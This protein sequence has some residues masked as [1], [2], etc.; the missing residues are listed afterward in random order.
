MEWFAFH[1]AS[2]TEL[3]TLAQD[4]KWSSNPFVVSQAWS[5]AN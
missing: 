5:E 3:A 2:S 4:R 1:V